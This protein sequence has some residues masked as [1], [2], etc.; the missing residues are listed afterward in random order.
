MFS[1]TAE[2][3]VCVHMYIKNVH[4]CIHM[5]KYMYIDTRM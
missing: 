4:A 3:Y 2:L 1:Y 5:Y